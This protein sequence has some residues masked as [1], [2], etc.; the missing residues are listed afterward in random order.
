MIEP[1]FHYYNNVIGFDPKEIKRIAV[2]NKYLAVMLKNGRIGVCSTLGAEILK[3]DLKF[4]EI[5][6][7]DNSHRILYNAYLN[8]KLNYDI[9]FEDEKDIFEHIDF[10]FKKNVVMIG[11]FKPLVKKFQDAGIEIAIF[12]KADKDELLIA[13]ELMD[14]YLAKAR[15]VILTSTTISNGTFDMIPGKTS[16][17]CDIFLL[18]PS[19]ILDYEMLKYRNIKKVYGSIFEPNDERILNLIEE[20]HGTRTFLPLGKKVN[21]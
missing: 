17:N 21:I 6:L 2:G 20:G 11:F 5:E 18:G 7:C 13:L 14:D 4:K 12:D 8:A 19:S 10:S 16:A 3:K 9:P 1:L 15:T